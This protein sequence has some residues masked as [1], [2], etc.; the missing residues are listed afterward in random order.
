MT[1]ILK[2][3]QEA[4]KQEY[5]VPDDEA[6]SDQLDA[7][8][9]TTKVFADLHKQIGSDLVMAKFDE[10]ARKFIIEAAKQAF[11]MTTVTCSTTIQE[12]R[13]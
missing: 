3:Q 9:Y 11:S 6:W 7:V 4:A 13:R 1:S 10:E 5:K 12:T 2:V 8:K